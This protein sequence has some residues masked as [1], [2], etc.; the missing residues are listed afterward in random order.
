MP[1]L[2]E[3]S[4]FVRDHS[5][6]TWDAAQTIDL[7]FSRWETSWRRSSLS[8]RYF[9][10][11]LA[12]PRQSD[13]PYSFILKAL[14]EEFCG[15]LHGV[16]LVE[17]ERAIGSVDCRRIP[18]V[19]DY[20]YPKRVSSGQ[21]TRG[22]LVFPFFQ[23]HTLAKVLQSASRLSKPCRELI[24]ESFK[25]IEAALETHGWRLTDIK[26][27]QLLLTFEQDYVIESAPTNLMLVD[28]SDAFRFATPSLF[29]N[30]FE[31]TCPFSPTFDQQYLLPPNTFH[32]D[33]LDRD[34]TENACLSLIETL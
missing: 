27:K 30:A 3:Q 16:A 7:G 25:E 2:Q 1:V 20:A 32:R 19:V 21:A 29:S 23:G 8:N 12:R 11:F 26:P 28:P 14:R 9:E 10:T 24:R 31:K 6:L 22:Y 13:G 17:R 15:S 18:P 4:A 34:A 33:G 5:S